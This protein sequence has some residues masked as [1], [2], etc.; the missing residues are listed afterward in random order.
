VRGLV[1]LIPLLAAGACAHSPAARS[2]SALS[3]R[4]LIG[5]WAAEGESCA[6]DSGISYNRDRTWIAQGAGGT[7]RIEGNSIVADMTEQWED[8]APRVRLPRPERRI[9]RIETAGPNFHVSRSEDGTLIRWL[10]CPE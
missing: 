8:G 10:R 9:E 2:G 1:A 5:A 7:W 6:S 3:D 4:W